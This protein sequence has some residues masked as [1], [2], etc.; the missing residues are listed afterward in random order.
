M[1]TVKQKCDYKVI[2]MK[3]NRVFEL[4]CKYFKAAIDI[5]DKIYSRYKLGYAGIQYTISKKN[6]DY[7]SINPY[8][9]RKEKCKYVLVNTIADSGANYRN[10]TISN[11]RTIINVAQEVVFDKSTKI[12]I[13]GAEYIVND[14]FFTMLGLKFD[15]MTSIQLTDSIKLNLIRNGLIPTYQFVYSGDYGVP[16]L[17]M[18]TDYAYV[19]RYDKNVTD[20]VDRTFLWF[21]KLSDQFKVY[22][23][24]DLKAYWWYNMLDSDKTRCYVITTELKNLKCVRVEHRNGTKYIGENSL[25]DLLIDTTID[26]LE[27]LKS[28]YSNNL[29]VA[30]DPDSTEAVYTPDTVVTLYIGPLVRRNYSDKLFDD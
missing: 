18:N 7:V 5:D 23:G 6:V 3:N 15:G 25:Y 8:T 4:T 13:D 2:D 16:V 28:I 27:E 24:S 17:K 19:I 29:T 26:K 22:K 14:N 10:D 20:Q 21:S 1:C 30:I 9:E 12:T 11:R